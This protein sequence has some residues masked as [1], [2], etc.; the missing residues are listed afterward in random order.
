MFTTIWTLGELFLIVVFILLKLS[1]CTTSTIELPHH[2]KKLSIRLS[3]VVCLSLASKFVIC[4][5][6]FVNVGAGAYISMYTH[7]IAFDIL[8]QIILFE[9]LG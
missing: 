7:L 9:L 1:F 5:L 4:A 3:N 2:L 6:K 8:G